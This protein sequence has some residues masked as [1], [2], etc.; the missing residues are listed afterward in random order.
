MAWVEIGTPPGLRL[1]WPGLR[2]VWRLVNYPFNECLS[3]KA[4][5]NS[6]GVSSYNLCYYRMCGPYPSLLPVPPSILI[7]PINPI[8]TEVFY[9]SK[10]RKRDEFVALFVDPYM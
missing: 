9:T 8:T 3:F 7:N 2:L 10:C 1:V 4:Q 5:Y 6:Q